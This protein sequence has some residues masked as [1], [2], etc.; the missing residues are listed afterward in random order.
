MQIREYPKLKNRIQ[1]L[2]YCDVDYPRL[3]W[4]ELLTIPM[5]EQ[6]FSVDIYDKSYC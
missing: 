6:L 3:A 1:K 4:R 5:K 2:G